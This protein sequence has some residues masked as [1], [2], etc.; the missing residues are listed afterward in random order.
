MP[1]KEKN[2]RRERAMRRKKQ[3]TDRL[4]ENAACAIL[5]QQ[6]RQDPAA[7]LQPT[8]AGGNGE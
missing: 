4:Q 2:N 8:G 6:G 3:K 5:K 7:V 1:R